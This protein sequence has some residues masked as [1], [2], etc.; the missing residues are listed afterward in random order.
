LRLSSA[1]K[2]TQAAV[3]FVWVLSAAL[4]LLA[5]LAAAQAGVGARLLAAGAVVGLALIALRASRD[6]RG[7][8]AM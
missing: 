5:V 3:T 4:A 6:I 2:G 7:G 8:R 1:F